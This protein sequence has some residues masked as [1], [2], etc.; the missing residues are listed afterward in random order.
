MTVS[1]AQDRA[2]SA[3]ATAERSVAGGRRPIDHSFIHELPLKVKL[4]EYCQHPGWLHFGKHENHY[5][6][7]TNEKY[8]CSDSF[9]FIVFPDN[10][11]Q[12]TF[13]TDGRATSRT[14]QGLWD[15]LL[16]FT[17]WCTH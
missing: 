3:V 11:R 8:T 13:D 10:A 4:G 9:G 17:K 5:F 16:E 15:R 14:S 2:D 6:R 1:P 7:Y 12:S